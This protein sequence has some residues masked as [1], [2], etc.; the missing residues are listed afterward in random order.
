MIIY[1]VPTYLR[2]TP[3][4]TPYLQLWHAHM[5][6]IVCMYFVN[7]KEL[8]NARERPRVAVGRER[9]GR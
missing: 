6:C 5:Y 4:T 7:V 2:I 3:S 8:G 1:F 9:Q